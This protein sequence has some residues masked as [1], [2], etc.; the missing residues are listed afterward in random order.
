MVISAV[1]RSPRS[2]DRGPCKGQSSTG[3]QPCSRA[4]G[5]GSPPIWEDPGPVISSTEDM[6]K[7]LVRAV[8]P[9]QDGGILGMPD[10]ELLGGFPQERLDG[11]RVGERHDRALRP[12]LPNTLGH[13]DQLVRVPGAQR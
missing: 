8:L 6:R 13:L 1:L 11:E 7:S 3:A 12:P 10:P 2:G 4:E 9:E 5:E